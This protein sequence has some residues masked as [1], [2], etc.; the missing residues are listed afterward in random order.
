MQSLI[1]AN[2]DEHMGRSTE[3]TRQRGGIGQRWCNTREFL[4]DLSVIILG[5]K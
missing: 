1:R 3:M 5:H 4:K 2:L